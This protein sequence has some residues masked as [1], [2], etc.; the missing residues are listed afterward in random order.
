MDVEKQ[1]PKDDAADS[2]APDD[3]ESL[4]E[5]EE[6][7][8]EAGEWVLAQCAGESVL[9]VGCGE[10][11]WTNVLARAGHR[12]HGI[13]HRHDKV[14]DAMARRN[15]A[16][17]DDHQLVLECGSLEDKEPPAAEALFDSVLI[18][19]KMDDRQHLVRRV[20]AASRFLRADGGRLV[21]NVSLPGDLPVLLPRHV[22]QLLPAGARVVSLQLRADGVR[23]C[24]ERGNHG[25]VEVL[26]LTEAELE[27]VLRVARDVESQLAEARHDLAVVNKELRMTEE[28]AEQRLAEVT[29]RVDE[30]ES[31][32]SFRLGYAQVMAL[33]SPKGFFR[34]PLEL[35]KVLFGA[36][37]NSKQAAPPK[38]RA[39]LDESQK[40]SLKAMAGEMVG[41][42][43][44][45]VKHR[46]DEALGDASPAAR[47]MAY[48]VAGRAC[49]DAG[50]RDMEFQFATLAL[51]VH[52]TPGSL[53]GFLQ[54][55]LR[56]RR[57]TEASAALREIH[58][59]AEAG[60]RYAKEIVAALQTT[61][62]YKI[63]VLEKINPRP[64]RWSDNRGDRLAYVLH[65]SLPYS[66]GGYATRSHGVASGLKRV[67]QDVVCLS[68]PG[69]PL[70]IKPE[71]SPVDVNLVDHIDE[72][73]YQRVLTPSRTGIP[74]YQYVLA[75]ADRMEAELR[76]LNPKAVMAASNYVTGLPALIA[77]R[78]LGVPFFYEVRGLWEITRMSRDD[79]F[80]ES[81]SFDVQRHIESSLAAE[82][83]HVFT[84]TEPM[85]EELIARG[86][87]ENRITLLPN[88]VDVH[89]F[90]PRPRDQALAAELGIG[91]D[92][93]VIGYIGTFVD[94]EGLE[95]LAE[96][97]V[98]LHQ[99]GHDFRLLLVGNE[100]ASGAERGP[101]TEEILRLASEGG[102]ESK[103]LMPGRI[104]HELVE[105]Y[106]SLLDI[107]PFPRKPW[108]VCEMVSPM[109][110]LEALAMRKAVVVSSVRALRE[111]I[112]HDQTGVV[113][114]KGDVDSLAA[115]LER[116]L[117]DA[118]LRERLGRAGREW[119][120][121][122]RTWRQV[123][124][125]IHAVLGEFAAVD[126]LTN[127]E[128]R[129]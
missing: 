129:I 86:V 68:R 112:Q 51:E 42:G 37:A 80:A 74:E 76:R 40:A 19:G 101:I 109:K 126:T 78:R 97:C 6:V 49:A 39:V 79:Q 62:S 100:N 14:Q 87:D 38:I 115:A 89:R 59:A 96:A 15:A 43:F 52:R 71:L 95:D 102:I 34:F 35:T 20:A 117:L 90:T 124:Q 108:P 113:Y 36:G 128:S 98:K 32:T 1:L 54:V 11:E 27:R 30:L 60:S 56:T 125:R 122:E 75:A 103:L 47:A 7:L 8:D 106:Y 93:L 46:I 94:Y 50:E 55:A 12:V 118:D 88:S 67:G 23:V 70:D 10:G 61:S 72:V 85:R 44:D 45:G 114:D 82:A 31:S 24:A 9:V 63:A 84:L 104:P 99:R 58:A 91:P 64:E 92:T 127:A 16:G 73:L 41:A 3:V 33:R 2:A 48:L 81:I 66:S 69:Y 22:A 28:C 53:R 110:P 83:E 120:G 105:S 5:S 119:V 107:C 57:M 77:A 13:D 25:A 29:A 111:M 4:A 121:N 116:L 17:F 123:G 65:N 18:V 26:D 21:V